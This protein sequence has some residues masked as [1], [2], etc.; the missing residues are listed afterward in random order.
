MCSSCKETISDRDSEEF[1]AADNTRGRTDD[2]H[3]VMYTTKD[4]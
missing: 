3:F 2:E 4:L 1:D